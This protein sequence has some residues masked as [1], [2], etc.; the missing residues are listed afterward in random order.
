MTYVTEVDDFVVDEI[1]RCISDRRFK[2]LYIDGKAVGF[3]TWHLHKN[4]DVFINNAYI[5]PEYR[6]FKNLLFLRKE[7]NKLKIDGKCYWKNHRKNRYSY[8]IQRRVNALAL[9]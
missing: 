2:Y 9:Q 1:K 3:Y 7:F 6:N 4:G 8:H 5:E